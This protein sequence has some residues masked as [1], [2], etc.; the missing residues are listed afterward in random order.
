MN[1]CFSLLLYDM[2]SQKSNGFSNVLPIKSNA[3]YLYGY[4]ASQS[5]VYSW[6]SQ[7]LRFFRSPVAR[8][9]PFV[10]RTTPYSRSR[11]D[12]RSK[13]QI[14]IVSKGAHRFS[15]VIWSRRACKVSNPL[16]RSET[17][18]ALSPP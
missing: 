5:S 17:T 4:C 16:P 13:Y 8:S 14:Y 9:L 18:P 12:S 6:A 11:R 10:S 7:Q 3:T 1:L 15:V 2:F